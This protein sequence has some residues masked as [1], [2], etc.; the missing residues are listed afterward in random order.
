MISEYHLYKL[1]SEIFRKYIV[2]PPSTIRNVDYL[3]VREA[4]IIEVKSSFLVFILQQS[5]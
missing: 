5:N 1:L 4:I 2:F 3:L